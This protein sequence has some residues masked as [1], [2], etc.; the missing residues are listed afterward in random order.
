M[1]E[2]ENF[3]WIIIAG[4]LIIG[5]ILIVLL[6]NLSKAKKGT[7]R[8]IIENLEMQ[9]YAIANK[10]VMFELAKLKTV[11]KS[12]RIIKLVAEWETRWQHLE[13]Q[14]ATIEDNIAYA[15]ECVISSEFDK[16]D[17]IVEVTTKD[18]N[19]LNSQIDNL[20]SEI[21]NLKTSEMRNRD[22]IIT[23]RQSLTELTHQFENNKSV[24]EAIET[25]ITESF[26]RV[27]EMFNRFDDHMETSNYDLADEVSEKIGNKLAILKQVLDKTPLY[28][29]SIE[30]DIFPLLEGILQS[31]EKMTNDGIYLGHLKIDAKISKLRQEI[32][33]VHG[34]LASFEFDKIEKI[35]LDVPKQAK[36]L[37]EAM[38]NEIDIKS[39]F[40]QDVSQLKIDAA[41]VVK[42][43]DALD[44]RY[45][46]IKDGCLLKSDDEDNLKSLTKEIK[47]LEA[48]VA[49][50]FEKIETGKNPISDLHTSVLGFLTQISEIAEQLRILN[51]E[52]TTITQTS[53]DMKQHAISLLYDINI[54]K[55]D[56]EK[57]SLET[58]VAHHL[59]LIER[60]D[61][62]VIELLE[63]TNHLPMDVDDVESAFKLAIN[64]VNVAKKEVVSAIE[65]VR[66][67]ERLLVYGNRYIEREGVYLMDLTIAE[68]QF[69]QGNFETTLE[70]MYKLLVDTEGPTFYNVFEGLKKEIGCEIL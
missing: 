35:L 63:K 43:S 56:F 22:G 49:Q 12:E 2:N 38:K 6:V 61:Q 69:K 15:E 23:L 27:D 11:R 18:L 9:K 64:A 7:Y 4:V 20:I 58:N 34:Y 46:S 40:I 32:K 33:T 66:L 42:E 28:Y 68:D 26:N 37:R 45:Q 48:S 30:I 25:E 44:I 17:E 5:V 14:L 70:K 8:E 36:V 62:Q 39:T 52:I 53:S 54:L 13:E 55:A 59:S 10:P 16:A 67:A 51:D 41:Y 57:T 1:F 24:Y 60:A 19:S 50:L 65:Q 47:I 3:L 31:Q 21:E 29:E